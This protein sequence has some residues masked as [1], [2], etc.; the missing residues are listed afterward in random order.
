MPE[1]RI[2]GERINSSNTKV[3]QMFTERNAAMLLDMTRE[4]VAGG[5]SYIDIN[6]SLLMTGERDALFWAVDTIGDVLD[7]GISIDTPDTE[8]LL[9]A[10]SRCGRRSIVNSFTSDED[11]LSASLPSIADAGAGVIV[12]LKNA[13]GIPPTAEGRMR[14]AEIVAGIVSRCGVDPRMVYLDPV[15]SPIATTPSGLT[16]ALETLRRL[17]EAYGGFQLIGGLSNISFG[18][19][20]RRLLNRTFLAMALS[21]GL[22]AV[23]CDPTDRRL[24]DTL[25]AAEAIVGGDPGCRRYLQRYR[26]RRGT[27]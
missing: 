23:I 7:V 4:Q 22:S 12:M 24:M 2:I 9:E 26:S 13:E 14:L 1:T 3:K 15:F 11:L 21:S 6:A 17:K 10:A 19:P 18:L 20:L 5:A 8:L 16:V 27:A 25:S